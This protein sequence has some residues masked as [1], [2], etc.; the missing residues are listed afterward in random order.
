MEKQTKNTVFQELLNWLI[1]EQKEVTILQS[2][3]DEV[4]RKTSSGKI[5]IGSFEFIA[6]EVDLS[7]H[8]EKVKHIKYELTKLAK[9]GI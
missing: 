3:V 6:L 1:D 8:K 5:D 7:A 2:K 4:Y 9:L